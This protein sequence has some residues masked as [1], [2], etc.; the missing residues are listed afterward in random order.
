MDSFKQQ[1]HKLLV[2]PGPIEVADDVLFAAAHPS[3]SHMSPEFA[4]VFQDCI[5]KLKQVLFTET[6]Q[7]I[8]V[9]G[10]GTLGW[11]MAASNL[12]EPGEDV[13]VLNTGYFGDSFAECLSIYGAKVEQLGA[14]VGDKPTASQIEEALKKRK[15]KMLT[16]TH[17]DTSTGVLSD[18]KEICEIVKR[19]SPDTITVLDGVCSVGS[20]L[21]K[22]DEWGV[23]V[24]L[25]A[26]QKGLGVPPG[27]CVTCVS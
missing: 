15:Y 18:A 23:D 10:S 4:G 7:P 11:D 9:A 22:M 24:V 16:F 27:L 12:V 5:A 19:V 8:I 20:E 14:P 2:I 26:S 13:L 6:A 1:P 17:V 25:A 21:I 3:V